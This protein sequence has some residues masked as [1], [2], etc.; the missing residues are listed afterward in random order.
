MNCIYFPRR[1]PSKDCLVVVVGRVTVGTAMTNTMFAIVVGITGMLVVN[2]TADDVVDN[3]GT[4]KA[5]VG[6]FNVDIWIVG[7]FVAGF[8]I[9]PDDGTI[10]AV[11]KIDRAVR[12]IEQYSQ[13]LIH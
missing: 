5:M 11:P 13:C 6:A 12:S 7:T 2:G 3:I 8:A 9:I 10:T 1:P 4:V